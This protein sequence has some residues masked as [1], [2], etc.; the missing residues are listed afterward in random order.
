MEAI[1]RRALGG[2]FDG[3]AMSGR[4]TASRGTLAQN[5]ALGR[6]PWTRPVSTKSGITRVSA[7]WHHRIAQPE[8]RGYSKFLTPL[9]WKS[10]PKRSFHSSKARKSQG[11]AGEGKESIPEG[12][13]S[14]SQRLKKLSREYGWSA[15]GVYLALSVLDFPFCFLLVRTIGTDKIAEAE[16]YVV[17]NVK[18]VIPEGIKQWWNDY[19]SALKQAGKENLGEGVTKDV[20]MAGWGVA[21]AE[22]K[23]KSEASKS[24]CWPIFSK[25]F[26]QTIFFFP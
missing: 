9:R 6:Q 17:S 18:K 26:L 12:T 22:E 3:L 1:I 15:V 21:E 14:I 16:H 5:K 7:P 10:T 13:L 8:A 2:T 11:P 20:E 25:S 24:C 19:R 4:V 23:N